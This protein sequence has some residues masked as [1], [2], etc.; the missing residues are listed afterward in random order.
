MLYCKR[1]LVI[2]HF[3]VNFQENC[4][5]LIVAV[6]FLVES[7]IS[8]LLERGLW[9]VF[10]TKQLNF[11]ENNFVFTFR[12]VFFKVISNFSFTWFLMVAILFLMF[13]TEEK[14]H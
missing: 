7:L 3:L 9:I 10:T 2:T 5:W 1:K 6:F 13:Q 11:F 8:E 4:L 12:T 14:M